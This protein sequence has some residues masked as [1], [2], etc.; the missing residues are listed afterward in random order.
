MSE[1]LFGYLKKIFTITDIQK[2]FQISEILF[3]VSRI[4]ISNI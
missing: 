2:M 3:W 1:I 4:T